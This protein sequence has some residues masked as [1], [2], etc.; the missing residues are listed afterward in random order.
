M[1]NTGK[2]VDDGEHC[3]YIMG[4]RVCMYCIGGYAMNLSW[5]ED[6]SV[7]PDLSDGVFWVEVFCFSIYVLLF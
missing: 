3:G 2:C 5:C 1:S 6:S 4:N 7:I